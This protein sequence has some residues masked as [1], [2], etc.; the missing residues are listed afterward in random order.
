MQFIAN[1]RLD[2]QIR[3]PKIK[4][5]AQKSFVSLTICLQTLFETNSVLNKTT[6]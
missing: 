3:D 6:P 1:D 2:W 5:M 4:R